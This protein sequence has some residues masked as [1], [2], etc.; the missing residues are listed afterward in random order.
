MS[1]LYYVLNASSGRY[2]DALLAARQQM[3]ATAIDNASRHFPSRHRSPPFLSFASGD[4]S[5]S[6]LRPQII[7]AQLVNVS[8]LRHHRSTSDRKLLTVTSAQFDVICSMFIFGCERRIVCAKIAKIRVC[9]QGHIKHL[10]G[11]THFTMPGPQS[12]C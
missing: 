8:A 9:G 7:A 6:S 4:T 10:V 2:A 12:L 3:C 1:V 11:P 5:S